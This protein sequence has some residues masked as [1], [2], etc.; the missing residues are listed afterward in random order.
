MIGGAED[1]TS[2]LLV[3]SPQADD[4]LLKLIIYDLRWLVWRA[5]Q[6][7]LMPTYIY[8]DP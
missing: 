7:Y 1:S 4:E 3:V 5:H 2:I 6:P 8:T